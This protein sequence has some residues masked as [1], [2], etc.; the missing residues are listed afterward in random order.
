[1]KTKKATIVC[2]NVISSKEAEMQ[3]NFTVKFAQAINFT[4]KNKNIRDRVGRTIK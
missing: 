3:V 4:E 2:T 1:M